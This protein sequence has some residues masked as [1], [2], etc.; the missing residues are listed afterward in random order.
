MPAPGGRISI[1]MYRTRP[2]T[3]STRSSAR[4]ES[5]R[6]S[7]T[8]FHRIPF[9]LWISWISLLKRGTRCLLLLPLT[10]TDL[11]ETDAASLLVRR[12]WDDSR[13][14]VC[15]VEWNAQDQL[16]SKHSH[17]WYDL[18][19][20]YEDQRDAPCGSTD[21]QG[22]SNQ[23]YIF[24][25]RVGLDPFR[26]LHFLYCGSGTTAVCFGIYKDDLYCCNVGDSRCIVGLSS[27]SK[28]LPFDPVS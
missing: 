10:V 27:I 13:G 17:L 21:K 3:S 7:Q 19:L 20:P 16:S 15:V 5:T 28:R 22:Q 9:V 14:H 2:W 26:F 18:E 4:L 12:Y 8:G 25:I 6:R 1:K 24:W 11:S 23:W